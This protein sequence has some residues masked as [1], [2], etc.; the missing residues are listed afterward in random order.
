[1]SDYVILHVS[2]QALLV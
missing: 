1:M 2:Q